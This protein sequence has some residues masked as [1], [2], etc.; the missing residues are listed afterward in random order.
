MLL[1]F[2]VRGLMC[3]PVLPRGEGLPSLC[4]PRLRVNGAGEPVEG[5]GGRGVPY[6][7]GAAGRVL[8]VD[9]VFVCMC[10]GGMRNW[11]FSSIVCM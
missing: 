1:R 2:L 6:D 5:D 8:L 9:Y 10:D 3:R 11:S 7:R 4:F